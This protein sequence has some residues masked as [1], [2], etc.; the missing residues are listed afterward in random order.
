LSQFSVDLDRNLLNFCPNQQK[1][2]PNQHDPN[3]RKFR[4][5]TSEFRGPKSPLMLGHSSNDGDKI[6]NAIDVPYICTEAKLGAFSM[7]S[8][9]QFFIYKNQTFASIFTMPGVYLMSHCMS[10]IF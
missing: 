1:I 2:D 9:S 3:N 5:S 4:F 6:A 7:A 10:T 8:P